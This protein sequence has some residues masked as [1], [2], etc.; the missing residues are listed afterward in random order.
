MENCGLLVRLKAKAGKEEELSAFL[1]SALPLAQAELG[2]SA[3]YAIQIEP[4]TF[5]IFDTFPSDMERNA[6]IGG[7]IAKA[8]FAKAPELLDAEPAIE[9]ISILAAK[10][11]VESF[12]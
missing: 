4:Q 3:W 8:L 1:K 10:N 12:T 6:H 9:K 5:G 2:T 11:S 7:A